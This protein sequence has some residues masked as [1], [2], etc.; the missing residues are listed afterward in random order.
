KEYNK[1]LLRQESS[2]Y[3]YQR[4]NDGDVFIIDMSDLEHDLA[5]TLLQRIFNVPNNNIIYDPPIVV[6]G[7]A[8]H[9]SPSALGEL[10]AADVSIYPNSNLVQQ[11][12]A[13][14][15][16][17]P[18][19]NKNNGP[20]A[21]I[22]CEVGNRQSTAGWNTKCQLWMN[23]VYVRHV[24]G[25]K[26]HKKRT[27]RDGQGRYHR[28]MT[29]RLWQQGI[30]RYQ[31]WEFGTHSRGNN[32]PTACNALGLPAFQVNIPVSEVFWDPPIPTVAGYAPAVPPLITAV[33]FSIDLYQIQQLVLN[34]QK[35]T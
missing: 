5:V 24:L 6:G 14:Y 10:I 29:A 18:P 9:Y 28:S 20:H 2:G 21:R 26:L 19:G 34:N 8:F 11:P 25:I 4:R 32:N 27:T 16:G 31:E 1:F 17:P 13:P 15:P 3:K 23:Q 33:N 22:V 35:N 7:D 12:R 30:A